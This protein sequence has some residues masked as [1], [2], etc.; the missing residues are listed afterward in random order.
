MRAKDAVTGYE[1]TTH[2][3]AAVHLPDVR[4]VL[5]KCLLRSP[6][7]VLEV[8]MAAAVDSLRATAM[9]ITWAD[10]QSAASPDGRGWARDG[11]ACLAYVVEANAARCAEIAAKLNGKPLPPVKI[12]ERPAGQL[13]QLRRFWGRANDGLLLDVLIENERWQ[14]RHGLD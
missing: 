7:N 9:T 3:H 13:E 4:G 1:L 8:K 2:H 5:A 11:M 10:V 6:A 14:R 12:A